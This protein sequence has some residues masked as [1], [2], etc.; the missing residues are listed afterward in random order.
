MNEMDKLLQEKQALEAQLLKLKQ[1]QKI[2]DEVFL[3]APR[4]LIFHTINHTHDLIYWVDENAKIIYANGAVERALGYEKEEVLSLNLSQ[5]STNFSQEAWQHLWQVIKEKGGL[6][7][8]QR[9]IT[10]QKQKLPFE[11]AANFLVFE[12]R[13]FICGI[14]RDI[15]ERKAALKSL[16]DKDMKKRALLNA[17]PDLIF[18]MDGEGNYQDYRGGWGNSFIPVDKIIGSNIKD[19]DLEKSLV[20]AILHR[21][22]RVIK[23]GKAETLNYFIQFQDER[24]RYYEDRCVKYARNL[25]VRVVRETTEIIEYQINLQNMVRTLEERN[26][27]L[28]NYSYHISHTLRAPITTIIGILQLYDKEALNVEEEKEFIKIMKNLALQL[29]DISKQL[30]NLLDTD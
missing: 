22:S 17:I 20:N 27:Q 10:K 28:E 12:G 15:S 2:S 29:D 26:K 24:I 7:F 16:K 21:N 14:V 30:N 3:A 23:T 5:I 4:G 11:V 8:E 25:V 9:L 18:I 1:Q 13:S 6:L 19:S